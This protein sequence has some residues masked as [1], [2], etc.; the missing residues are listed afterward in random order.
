MSFM[1]N[2]DVEISFN[3]FEL[4][5]KNSLNV[6]GVEGSSWWVGTLILS[7]TALREWNSGLWLV[8]RDAVVWRW[9]RGEQWSG[10]G[11]AQTSYLVALILGSGLII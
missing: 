9:W 5:N 4:P 3:N 6:C 7:S 10:V 8:G 2:G 1:C 11:Q